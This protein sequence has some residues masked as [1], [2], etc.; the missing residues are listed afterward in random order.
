[1]LPLPGGGKK[2]QHTHLTENT[3]GHHSELA[4]GSTATGRGRSPTG[5]QILPYQTGWAG[6]NQKSDRHRKLSRKS[7]RK[8]NLDFH[9]TGF[10]VSGI[11]LCGPPHPPPQCGP[12]KLEMILKWNILRN[13]H[14]RSLEI[15]IKTEVLVC[16]FLVFV[17]FLCAL[18]DFLVIVFHCK[19][20][21]P[22]VSSLEMENGKERT[23]D[24]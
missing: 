21:R 4:M 19:R 2:A 15:P 10:E 6:E 3:E 5:N 9:F 1:M 23:K 16:R 11:H 14:F 12:N 20:K 22:A 18:T 13:S 7:E 8:C 24:G 17:F